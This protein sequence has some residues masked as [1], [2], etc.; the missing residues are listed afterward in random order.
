MPRAHN[1]RVPKKK[2]R[3]AGARTNGLVNVNHIEL[4][5]AKSPNGSE[6]ASKIRCNRGYGTISKCGDACPKWSYSIFRWCT[7]AGAHNPGLVPHL[8]ERPR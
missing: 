6:R 5:F 7:I 8:V 1:W 4:F 2:G 3:L